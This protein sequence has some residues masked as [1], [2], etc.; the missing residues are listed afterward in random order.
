[1][2]SWVTFFQLELGL[3]KHVVVVEHELQC[4]TNPYKVNSAYDANNR[5]KATTPE[6]IWVQGFARN[7]TTFSRPWMRLKR[8]LHSYD[9]LCLKPDTKDCNVCNW[10]L[11]E[12]AAVMELSQILGYTELWN[13]GRSIWHQERSYCVS[14]ASMHLVC[15]TTQWVMCL[16]T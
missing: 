10:I 15:L 16:P 2:P 5:K 9:P 13:Q 4:R 3:S 8:I 1:M 11:S 6:Y 7:S 14:S 12:S